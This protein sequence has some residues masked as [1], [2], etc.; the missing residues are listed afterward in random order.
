MGVVVVVVG[1][2]LLLLLSPSLSLS[3]SRAS[4]SRAVF[5][6]RRARTQR[7]YAILALSRVA[8]AA[9]LLRGEEVYKESEGKKKKKKKE[10]ERGG[11]RTR[12]K[13]GLSEG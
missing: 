11:R 9:S 13:E 6:S 7:S 3:L 8:V 4:L 5:F 1:P 2:T 10:N 12:R